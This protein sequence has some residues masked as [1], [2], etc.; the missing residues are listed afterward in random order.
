MVIKSRRIRW[1]G[2]VARMKAMRNA[3]N[4]SVGKPERKRLLG[5]PKRRW[6]DNIKMDFRE[7]ERKCMN[8]MHLAQDRNQ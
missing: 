3:H 8:C 5:R 6:E 4:A 1:V 2:H 7:T